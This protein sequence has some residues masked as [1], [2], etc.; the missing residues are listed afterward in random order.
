MGATDTY[1]CCTCGGTLCEVVVLCY[2]EFLGLGV[3][4]VENNYTVAAAQLWK[5]FLVLYSCTGSC[6]GL[7]CNVNGCLCR[8]EVSLTER[9]WAIFCCSLALGPPRPCKFILVKGFIVANRCVEFG[10]ASWYLS[11]A[12]AV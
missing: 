4:V 12:E 6:T 11:P 9:L 1:V 3:P 7:I 10:M 2:D 5:D 8:N